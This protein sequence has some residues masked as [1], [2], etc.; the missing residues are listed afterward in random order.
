M[1]QLRNANVEDDEDNYYLLLDSEN[2]DSNI[3]LKPYMPSMH[4]SSKGYEDV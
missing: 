2:D 4:L 1:N 3:P